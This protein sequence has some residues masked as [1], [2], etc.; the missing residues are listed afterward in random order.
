M[1]EVCVRVLLM[2]RRKQNGDRMFLLFDKIRTNTMRHGPIA[3]TLPQPHVASCLTTVNSANSPSSTIV[4]FFETWA[5]TIPSAPIHYPFTNLQVFCIPSKS[6][7]GTSN[8]SSIASQRARTF[9]PPRLD[10]HPRPAHGDWPT[11]ASR[12]ASQQSDAIKV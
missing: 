3:T 1:E 8:P 2:S 5:D 10:M 7:V 11:H 12:T 6:N 4:Q 9:S